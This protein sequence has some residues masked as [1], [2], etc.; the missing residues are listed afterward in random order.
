M[1][2]LFNVSCSRPFIK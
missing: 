1:K 2:V